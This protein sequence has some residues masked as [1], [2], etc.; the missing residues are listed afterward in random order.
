MSSVQIV[1]GFGLLLGLA[2]IEAVLF[3]LGLIGPVEVVAVTMIGLVVLG[4]FL[5]DRSRRR[6][7]GTDTASHFRWILKRA[8]RSPTASASDEIP[9]SFG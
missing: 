1:T 4:V 8:T 5:Y 2:G 9:P 3:L 7:G 6:T